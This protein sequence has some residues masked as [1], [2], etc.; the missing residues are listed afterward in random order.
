M[1]SSVTELLEYTYSIALK[2]PDPSTQNGALIFNEVQDT[3]LGIGYNDFPPGTDAKYWTGP[4]EEKYT[5][6]VH[7]E[8]AAIIAVAQSG[9]STI[10]ATLVC[11]WAA[12]ANCAKHIAV[13]GIERLVRHSFED[14]GADINSHW[15]TEVQTG[16]EILQAAGIVIIEVP[17]VETMIRLRRN[18]QLWPEQDT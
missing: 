14:N 8:T 18:G 13:S 11:P 15:Y 2:S 6:V 17:P 9:Y 1:P 4:K 5:R 3:I 7:A 16:D 10:G 12:C